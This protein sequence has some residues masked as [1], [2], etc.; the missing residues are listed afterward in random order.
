M[1]EITELLAVLDIRHDDLVRGLYYA[2][3]AQEYLAA[4]PAVREA[5][6]KLR[7]RMFPEN[8]MATRKSYR[9]QVGQAEMLKNRLCS[10]DMAL[11]GSLSTA[12]GASLSDA[13]DELFQVASTMGELENER[14]GD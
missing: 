4:D 8:L 1:L 10:D 9:G 13:L 6:R 11:L 5:A 2:L 3:L 12:G 7:T 14:S